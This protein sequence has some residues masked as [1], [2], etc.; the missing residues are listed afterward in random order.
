MITI[1]RIYIENRNELFR[2]SWTLE[3]VE[4]ENGS[5]DLDYGYA[6]SESSSYQGTNAATGYSE[7][8]ASTSSGFT[9]RSS[10]GKQSVADLCDVVNKISISQ[11]KDEH[12]FK[13]GNIKHLKRIQLFF[14]LG[15]IQFVSKSY[16]GNSSKYRCVL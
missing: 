15:V 3:T 16:R 14:F 9:S 12:I 11:K 1:V 2:S 4:S 7:S 10:S 5:S 13:P 8:T 6:K